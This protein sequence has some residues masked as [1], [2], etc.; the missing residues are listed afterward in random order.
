MITAV[1]LSPLGK[2]E[3]QRSAKHISIWY[4]LTYKIVLPVSVSVDTT[5]LSDFTAVVLSYT[6]LTDGGRG[7]ALVVGVAVDPL[8]ISVGVLVAC[9]LALIMLSVRGPAFE[10]DGVAIIDGASERLGLY[11]DLSP[12]ANVAAESREFELATCNSRL[13]LKSEGGA[14]LE[15]EIVASRELVPV[16]DNTVS[17]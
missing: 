17:E 11:V 16:W 14:E 8:S 5:T 10:A 1:L 2:N 3:L 12:C 7:A 13:V 6:T 4:S 15:G 9:V